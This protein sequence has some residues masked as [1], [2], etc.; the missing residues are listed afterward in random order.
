MRHVEK[1]GDNVRYPCGH[2]PG[3]GLMQSRYALEALCADQWVIAFGILPAAVFNYRV[4]L[5][6]LS[7]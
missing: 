5:R 7:L 4:W 6:S 3:H 1:I 2:A